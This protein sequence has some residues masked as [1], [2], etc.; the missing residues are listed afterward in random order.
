MSKQQTGKSTVTCLCHTPGCC[1]WDAENDPVPLS[2]WEVH[3]DIWLEGRAGKGELWGEHAVV[4][5]CL[6]LRL[7]PQRGAVGREGDF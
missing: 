2:L 5:I 3:E 1:S 6:F 7:S 4:W